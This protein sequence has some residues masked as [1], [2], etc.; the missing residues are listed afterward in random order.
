M[1][2]KLQSRLVESLINTVIETTEALLADPAD[3]EARAQFA[4]AAAATLNGLT[5][6][7]TAGF[8]YPNHAIEHALSAL[9]NVPHGAGLSVVVPAWMKWFLDRNPAQFERFAR[10][11]FG[12]ESGEQGIAALQSWYD[13]I[14]TP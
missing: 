1:H 5:Y 9:F 14:G 2:P 3:Y 11:V 6:S 7:G 8:G 4:W 13:K 10:N 12:V